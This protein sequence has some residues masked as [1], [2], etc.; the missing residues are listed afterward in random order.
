MDLESLKQ[1][2]I[3]PLLRIDRRKD[4][5]CMPQHLG[6]VLVHRP[7]FAAVATPWC[8]EEDQCLRPQRCDV[9]S[10]GSGEPAVLVSK[11]TCGCLR[12]WLSKLATVSSAT[13][14]SA[15]KRE[16]SIFSWA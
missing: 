7:H 2:A 8:M 1:L 3:E 13:S 12:S 5:W 14:E 16:S 4:D 9:F 15:A 11:T 6:G 10:F